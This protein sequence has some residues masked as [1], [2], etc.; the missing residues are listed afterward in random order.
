MTCLFCTHSLLKECKTHYFVLNDLLQEY[1]IVNKN[2]CC[3]S[4]NL[5]FFG[6]LHAYMSLLLALT[7][8][9]APP[10]YNNIDRSSPIQGRT[11]GSQFTENHRIHKNKTTFC[12]HPD[13]LQKTAEVQVEQHIRPRT[14]WKDTVL[15]STY[16]YM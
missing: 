15:L 5:N 16:N 14:S 13:T 7:F 3:N 1:A 6:D 11:L 10:L 8:H 2:L 12:Y 4:Q 9:K